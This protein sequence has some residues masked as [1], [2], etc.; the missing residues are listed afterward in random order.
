LPLTKLFFLTAHGSGSPLGDQA[1]FNALH[2]V[3]GKCDEKNNFNHVKLI[4]SVKT[5]VGHTESVSGLIAVLRNACAFESERFGKHLHFKSL[6]P[7][8]HSSSGFVLPVES[9]E[10]NDRIVNVS[11]SNRGFSG[12]NIQ[13]FIHRIIKEKTVKTKIESFA[14]SAKTQNSLNKMVESCFNPEINLNELKMRSSE[15]FKFSRSFICLQHT[16]RFVLFVS[17]VGRKKISKCVLKFFPA[18]ELAK[19]FL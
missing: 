13:A 12:T 9:V 4:G 11:V 2:R 5:N 16:V 8:I 10:L 6:S 18:K 7:K 19:N 1:E 17:V 3:F 14:V 15:K